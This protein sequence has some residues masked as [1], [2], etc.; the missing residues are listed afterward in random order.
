MSRSPS[1]A[2]FV[3]SSPS[4]S[5]KS[6]RY[7]FRH[8]HLLRQN[9]PSSPLRVIAHID[10]DAFYAQCE[11]VRLGTP[12]D[13]PLAV[14]QWE[15]LIAINYAARPFGITRMLSATE[16]KK[17]CPELVL[18]HVATF[19]EGEGGTWAY[20]D[21]A[22][23]RIKTDKV[24]LDPYRAQSRKILSTIKEEVS[25]QRDQILNSKDVVP[26]E[27]QGAKVEK[28]SIDEVFIDLSSLV[29][30]ILYQRYPELRKPHSTSDKTTRLPSPPT[31]A[32][33]WS[34]EDGLV[35]LDEQETEE[36]DPDWDDVAM[37]IGAEIIRSIR[38]AIW[39]KLSY[40][41]S[42]GI[43]RNKMMSKLGSAQNKPNKQTIIRNRAIQNFLGG[44][45]FTRIR[46]LGGK[47]G[48]QIRAEFGTEQ[49][50]EL[51]NISVEQFKAKLDDDT[52]VWLYNIIR[53]IDD[54]EVNTRTQIKSMLSAKSFRPSINSADQARKWLRIFAA[55]LYNSLHHRIG[56]QV[57]SK[58]SPIRGGKMITEDILYDL[59]NNLLN[60]VVAEARAWPCANLSV[61]VTGFEEG[62]VNNRAINSFFS[63]GQSNPF[64]ESSLTKMVSDSLED[65]DRPAKV[66]KVAA[67]GIGEFFKRDSTSLVSSDGNNQ[68]PSAFP[69]HNMPITNSQYSHHTPN[70]SETQ[71][72]FPGQLYSLFTCSRC[73]EEMSEDQR[74]EHDDWHFAKDLEA[75]EL[76]ADQ[77][78]RNIAEQSSRR[79]MLDR[80]KTG[81]GR[82]RVFASGPEKGQKRLFFG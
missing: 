63:P 80:K 38:S 10:L 28:A 15:S 7:T 26:L 76:R 50:K 77:T 3:Q 40:T 35:D 13:T 1:P 16:A 64:T 45:Q 59:S 18:Q 66:R 79:R 6:S 30:A 36:D 57:H 8:L 22:S 24:S 2:A 46:M 58:T 17:R 32:L 48:E 65:R 73:N 54:S 31:T 74:E 60:Q 41:C 52:A 20:R 81:P 19:R 56:S 5:I 61:N 69:A 72:E 29:Y 43:A 21:D 68:S 9:S 27:F 51:L 75:Q 67:K 44:F 70:V 25:R 53:G 12:R 55:D 47:L 11:M 34:S 37:L 62:P 42:A 82:P 33:E 4:T 23:K 49:V 78:S 71:G 39:D 14:Q